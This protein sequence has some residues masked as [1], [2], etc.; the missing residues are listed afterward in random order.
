MVAGGPAHR[1]VTVVPIV[2][3]VLVHAPVMEEPRRSC[4]GGGGGSEGSG[5]RAESSQCYQSSVSYQS[6][7]ERSAW[8]CSQLETEAQISLI[9][10][11]STSLYR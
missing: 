7:E 4:R 9:A 6:K 8:Y 1:R 3:Q 2:E 5:H 10:Q 11:E